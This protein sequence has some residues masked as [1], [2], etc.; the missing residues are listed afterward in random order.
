MSVSS[1]RH[2]SNL[3][4]ILFHNTLYFVKIFVECS[5]NIIEPGEIIIFSSIP[6]CAMI[7][8]AASCLYDGQHTL[9]R[10]KG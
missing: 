1:L 10:G 4:L 8:S 2:K 9:R 3:Y 7:D 6:I 5:R